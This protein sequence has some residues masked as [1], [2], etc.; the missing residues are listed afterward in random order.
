[1]LVPAAAFVIACRFLFRAVCNRP[2]RY[3]VSSAE[4]PC[5]QQ[6]PGGPFVCYVLDDEASSNRAARQL[7]AK[8]PTVIGVDAEWSSAGKVALLQLAFEG[9]ALLFRLSRMPTFPRALAALLEDVSILKTGVAVDGDA[10]RC[11]SVLKTPR[12]GP[13][14]TSIHPVVPVNSAYASHCESQ[15]KRGSSRKGAC[16]AGSCATTL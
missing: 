7:H 8:K 3:N 5:T 14:S 12:P 2:T 4:P 9:E 11:A 1:M 15:A 16:T 10:Q 6:L 13:S